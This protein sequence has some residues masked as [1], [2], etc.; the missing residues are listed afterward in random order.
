M[1]VHEIEQA[2]ADLPPAELAELADWFARHHADR[3][4]EQITRDSESGKLDE[5]IL[6][7]NAQF[8]AGTAKRI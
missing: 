6:Q 7:A 2:I 8:D 4:D 1:S 5:L 3:W